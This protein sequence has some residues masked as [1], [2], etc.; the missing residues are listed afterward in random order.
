MENRFENATIFGHTYWVVLD[1]EA[2]ILYLGRNLTLELGNLILKHRLD[3]TS[4]MSSGNL[5]I[6]FLKRSN[7]VKLIDVLPLPL[8]NYSVSRHIDGGF[9]HP[10][11]YSLGQRGYYKERHYNGSYCASTGGPRESEVEL[12]CHPYSLMQI[13][14]VSEP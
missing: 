1:T 11:N 14:E 6:Q 7:N 2:D 8:S 5:K 3:R 10:L 12:E 4:E 9:Y 13:L